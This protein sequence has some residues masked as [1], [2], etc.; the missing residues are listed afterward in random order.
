MQPSVKTGTRN[1]FLLLTRLS[2]KLDTTE[3]TDKLYLPT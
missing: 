3:G 2:A 1:D